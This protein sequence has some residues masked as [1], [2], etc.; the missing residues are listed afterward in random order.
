MRFSIRSLLLLTLIAGIGIFAAR[1]YLIHHWS[2]QRLVAQLRSADVIPLT[3]FEGLESWGNDG[4]TLDHVLGK[5][6]C[7]GLTFKHLD[8]NE[9]L[10]AASKL[11][12]AV[13]LSCYEV[14]P[15][16]DPA[17]CDLSHV[18]KLYLGKVDLQTLERWLEATPRLKYLTVKPKTNFDARGFQAIAKWKRLESVWFFSEHIEKGEIV[19]LSKLPRLSHLGFSSGCWFEYDT[20]G[21]IKDCSLVT[22][23]SITDSA[24]NHRLVP[25]IAKLDQITKLDFSGSSISDSEIRLLREMHQLV[26]LDLMHCKQLTDRSAAFINQLESVE[27]V[28]LLGTGISR[29]KIDRDIFQLDW[30]M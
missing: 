2:P 10:I 25:H 24:F 1:W 20:I 29:D 30:I 22:R 15:N 4:V 3:D 9:T 14:S 27:S 13:E 26:D 18:S 16:V 12:S 28:N 5:E 7:I 6:L 19:A 23:L 8:S 11:K 21:E 17:C